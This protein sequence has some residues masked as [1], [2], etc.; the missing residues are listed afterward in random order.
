[1]LLGT[2]CQ[3]VDF[4]ALRQLE[5]QLRAADTAIKESLTAEINTMTG[6]AVFSKMEQ[7]LSG[8]FRDRSKTIQAQRNYSMVFPLNTL[9]CSEI[10]FFHL[11]ELHNVRF[12]VAKM[13]QKHKTVF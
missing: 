12:L 9:L 13:K 3:F 5:Q 4:A 11:H 7:N 8:V 1:M 6:R 10:F 2:P